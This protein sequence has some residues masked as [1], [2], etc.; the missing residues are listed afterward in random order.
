MLNKNTG[1]KSC[2]LFC[3]AWH[4]GDRAL[5]TAANHRCGHQV[6]AGGSK[7]R[8]KDFSAADSKGRTGRKASRVPGLG[9]G[10]GI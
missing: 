8:T 1:K 10:G 3:G 9:E 7:G 2:R 4:S 6:G 5:Y